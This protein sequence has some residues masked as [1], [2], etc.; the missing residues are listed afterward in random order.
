MADFIAG[1][2]A[3]DDANEVTSSRR[4]AR[5]QRRQIKRP[6]QNKGILSVI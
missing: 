1:D 6:S 2:E 5:L 3:L 4:S